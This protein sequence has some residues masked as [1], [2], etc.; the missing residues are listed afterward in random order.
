MKIIQSRPPEKIYLELKNYGRYYCIKNKR[1]K[2]EIIFEKSKNIIDQIIEINCNK[3][4]FFFTSF[5][6]EHKNAIEIIAYAKNNNLSIEIVT[7]LEKSNELSMCVLNSM[8][9]EK[10]KI[11]IDYK[12]LNIK[13][14]IK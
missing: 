4:S 8:L 10:D 12:G 9:N 14:F 6:L 5:T 7:Q 1:K 2:S 3:L 11:Y 13:R